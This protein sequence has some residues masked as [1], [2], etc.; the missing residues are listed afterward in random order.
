MYFGYFS[1]SLPANLL[2]LKKRFIFIYLWLCWVFVADFRELFSSCGEWELLSTWGAR[3]SHCSS[4]S[5]RRPRALGTQ[6]SEVGGWQALSTGSV[7]VGTGLVSPQ[8]VGSSWIRD[9]TM[10]PILAGGFFT[11][12]PAGK[13]SFLVFDR[14]II[15]YKMGTMFHCWPNQLLLRMDSDVTLA[16]FTYN[17]ARLLTP[18]SV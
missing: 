7:A 12:E 10:S 11:T 8:H 6:V 2:P 15:L 14:A 1:I 4:F 16:F 13:P 17:P 9:L 5:C 3:A 18:L